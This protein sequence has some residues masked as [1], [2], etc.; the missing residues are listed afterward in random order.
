MAFDVSSEAS[1]PCFGQFLALFGHDSLAKALPPSLLLYIGQ[2]T[3][4]AVQ[5][6]G[7]CIAADGLGNGGALRQ[8]LLDELFDG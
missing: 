6:V 8:L 1:A 3:G 7:S 2:F 5:T 4:Y